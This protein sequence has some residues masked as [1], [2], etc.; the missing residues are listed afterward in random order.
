MTNSIRAQNS[1]CHIKK[2]WT[3]FLQVE[4]GKSVKAHVRVL[5]DNK[6]P[7]LAKYFRFLNLKLSAASGIISLQ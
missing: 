4:I 6:K 7:F 5:D 2:T 1:A 3:G